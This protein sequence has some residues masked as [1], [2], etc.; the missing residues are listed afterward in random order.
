MNENFVVVDGLTKEFILNKKQ[1]A[2]EDTTEK[3][4]VAV[5]NIS[6]EV[7]RGEIFGLLGPNGAGK[8][9]TLRTISTLIKAT[10]GQVLV[11]GTDVAKE[12]DAAR[13]K[14]TLLTNELKLDKHFTP[15]YIMNFFGKMRGIE[16]SKINARK[17]ELFNYFE[18]EKFAD[19]KIKDLSTGMKQKA[20]IAVSLVHDPE[21]IIFD[22]PTSGL[23]IITARSVI[24][25]L[26][27]AKQ[28][29]KTVII[30]THHMHVAEKLADRLAIIM[31][32]KIAAYGDLKTVIEST[33]SDN[34]ETAFFKLYDKIEGLS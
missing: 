21:L 31:R 6:F 25:Y 9:T 1:M 19:T 16:Q 8:T 5:D 10:S 30:S 29:G 11:D 28:R 7:K 18:I 3:I 32:G 33:E 17:A 24:N 26:L 13:A 27:A 4:K 23:D 20:S 12:P 15:N 14:L 2:L 22:E 34:L